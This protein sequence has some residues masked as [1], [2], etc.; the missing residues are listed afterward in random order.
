MFSETLDF[1]F[2]EYDF[3]NDPVCTLKGFFIN[4]NRKLNN[5]IMLSALAIFYTFYVFIS[6]KK[7]CSNH[8]CRRMVANLAKRGL[9]F[10]KKMFTYFNNEVLSGK[11][12]NLKE[13]ISRC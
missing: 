8:A 10:D 11:L 4:E 7:L 13:E 3:S 5:L 12:I 9:I 1:F 2:R 6:R